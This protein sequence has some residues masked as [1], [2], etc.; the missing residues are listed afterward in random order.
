MG[1]SHALAVD[2]DPESV[3][4]TAEAAE[5]N[6]VKDTIEEGLGSVKEIGEGKFSIQKAPV[7]LANILA[8]V[9]IRLFDAGMA[10]LVE[11]GGVIILAGILADQAD[12]V[13]DSAGKH[14]LTFVEKRQS[15]D[16]VALVCRC[17]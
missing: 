13:I 1:A 17:E 11:P 9:L 14:G 16:W 12:G 4:A 15:G 8:P 6:E 10:D 3:K 2:I 5:A 7:V